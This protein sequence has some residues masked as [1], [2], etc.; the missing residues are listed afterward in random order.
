MS[1]EIDREAVDRRR[2]RLTRIFADIVEHAQVQCLSRCPY[3]DSRDLCTAR[4]G[5]RN[6]GPADSEHL[7]PVC[8]CD[9]ELDYRGAWEVED[10]EKVL[11]QWRDETKRLDATEA[12]TR[13]Q[14]F[15]CDAAVGA[16]LF[17]LADDLGVQVDSS[18]G[19]TGNCHECVVEVLS[20][21]EHLDGRTEAEGFLSE[22]YR[23]A[24]QAR[25]VSKGSVAL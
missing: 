24:C 12:T 18:C 16:T 9:G 1:E 10:P 13:P 5:C 6:Q 19:R 21:D 23:L 15:V 14:A 3:R 20:G 2:A 22:R 17:E 7:L 25:V 8:Q 4:F 11:A